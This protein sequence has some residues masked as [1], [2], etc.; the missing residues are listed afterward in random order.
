MNKKTRYSL[1]IPAYNEEGS[2]EPLCQQLKSILKSLNWEVV[3]VDDG[4]TDRS[5]SILEKLYS[6]DKRIKVIQFR[7][8]FGKAPAL[9]AGFEMAKGDVIITMDADLQ[10]DPMD[11]PKF[12]KKIDEGFDVVNGW[13]SQRDDPLSKTLPSKI[14]NRLA[15][16]ITGIKLHD[17]NCGFKAFKKDVLEDIDLYGEMHRYIPIFLAAKGYKLAEIK[18]RHHPRKYG[19]SKYGFF[20]LLKGF[21]DLLY[22]KF[23]LDFSTRPIHF[24]GGIG[25]MQYILALAIFVQQIIKA[26]KIKYF[27]VGPVLSLGILFVTTGTLCILFGFLAE[28]QIRTYYAK[29]KTKTFAIKKILK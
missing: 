8:N 22:V 4:S 25:I 11:I 14:Y 29:S 12:A 27:N 21:L 9:A 10:N 23:W 5:F 19:K 17:S 15:Q 26:Y 1:V 3:F 16:T 13:R 24:L 28:I 18:I 6:K 2:L 7:K 20:R